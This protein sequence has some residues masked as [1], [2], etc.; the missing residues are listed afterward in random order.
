M[1]APHARKPCPFCGWGHSERKES[2]QNRHGDPYHWI[3][4]VGCGCRGPRSYE[5]ARIDKLWNER[6]IMEHK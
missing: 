2:A 1:S 4:C 3:E 5:Q 6:K